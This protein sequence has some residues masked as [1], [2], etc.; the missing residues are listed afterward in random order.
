MARTAMV[1]AGPSSY[2]CGTTYEG[3]VYWHEKGETAD[4][5]AFSWFIE[6]AD[7]YLDEERVVLAKTAWPDIANQQGPVT[8]TIY[9]RLFPQGDATTWGPWMLAP[10]QDQQ[11][12]KIS[13]RLFRIRLSGDSAPSRPAWAA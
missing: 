7:L 4:G 9:S 2:P 11:D 1:D 13:G 6:T 5:G 3:N 12:F 8:L 10:G